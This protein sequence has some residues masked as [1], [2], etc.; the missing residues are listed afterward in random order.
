MSMSHRLRP[1]AWPWQ[2]DKLSPLLAL[3]ALALVA[4]T[5]GLA[6]GPEDTATRVA[7]AVRPGLDPPALVA[8][9]QGGGSPAAIAPPQLTPADV[10]RVDQFSLLDQTQEPNV[11]FDI[12]AELRLVSPHAYWY[13]ERGR[14][15]DA[16]DLARA[17]DSFETTLYP[18]IQRAIGGGRELGPLTLLHANLPGVNGYFSSADLYPRWVYPQSNERP[19]L[20]LNVSGQRVGSAAYLH[21]LTHELAHLFHFYVNAFEDTW[22]KEGLGELAQELAD[23]SFRYGVQAF[24]NRPSTQLTGWAPPGGDLAAHYQAGY[25]FLRYVMERYGGPDALAALIAAGGRGPESV[26]AFLAAQ[27]RPERFDDLFRDWVIANLVQDARVADGRYGYQRPPEGRPRVVEITGPRRE[28]GRV[29]QYGTDY[30]RLRGTGPVRVRFQ[31][32]PTTALIG[33]DPPG[34]GPFWWSHR[35]DRLDTR[36]TRALD[37]RGVTQATLTFDLRVDTEEGYDYGYVMVSTDGGARWQLLGGRHTTTANP[38]GNNLGVGYTGKSGGQGSAGGTAQWVREEIDLS[39]YAGQQLA[40]RFEYVTDDAYNAE[41]IAV[42][43]IAV[44]EL[45]WQ[46]DGT[47]WTAEGFV[48]VENALPQRFAV[49]AVEYRGAG[50]T[51]RQV[52]LDA[53][54]RATLDLPD[55]GGE[56]TAAVIAVSGLTPVTLQPARYT[57]DVEPLAR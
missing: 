4:C 17:A 20:Y 32:A 10:G 6:A 37:L 35:G 36:L 38:T 56:L 1:R 40:L 54:G 31:G 7:T 47:G 57:L 27:G 39:P 5:R 19:L 44:P 14:Q 9:I 33:A 22:L 46:D 11:K 8:R 15:V 43:N 13:V 24:F 52:P 41:G 30:Y 25:L 23:P 42:A 48:W 21:T 3:L 51:V 12:Q 50:I 28:E 26:D 55:L 34:G 16:A 29:A 45:G 2:A 18:T 49:Q 53:D